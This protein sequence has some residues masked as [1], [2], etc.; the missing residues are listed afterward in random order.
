MEK[1]QQSIFYQ[2]SHCCNKPLVG[3]NNKSEENSYYILSSAAEKGK[4]ICR[5]IYGLK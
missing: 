2:P 4:N 3:P 5:E 1:L